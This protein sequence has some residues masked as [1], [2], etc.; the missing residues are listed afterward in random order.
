MRRLGPFACFCFI[1]AA[2]PAP[3]ADSRS[4]VLVTGREGTVGVFDS[5]TLTPI[6]AIQSGAMTQDVSARPDGRMLFVASA[7][8]SKPQSC[9][10]VYSVDLAD[11]QLC[12][13]IEPAL[14]SVPA[15]DGSRLFVQRGNVG[16]DAVDAQSLARLPAIRAPGVYA[17]SPS[18]DG[19]WLAGTTNW[20][21]PSL[22]FFDLQRSVLAR[23]LAVPFGS[24]SGA[25]A[26]GDYYL[27]SFDGKQGALWKASPDSGSLGTGVPVAIP[28]V[29][30]E[31]QPVQQRLI[32]GS[33]RLFLYEMFGAKV[34]RRAHC[35]S[36]V[37]GGAYE[38]DPGTGAILGRLAP[39]VWFRNLVASDDGETLFGIDANVPRLIAVDRRTGSVQTERSL[40]PDVW[41]VSLA[42]IPEALVPQGNWTPSECRR[43]TAG[44]R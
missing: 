7:M 35:G 11:G 24:P 29:E 23:R 44:I 17:L 1:L 33:G 31:C 6:G 10:A 12:F 27:Y 22:D 32:S 42:R 43:A 40:A 25:W 30:E 38:I 13:L 5:T 41:S 4:V 16:I 8:R 19:H 15:T 39:A 28:G 26:G 37:A 3:A 34:D 20:Q 18:P 36:P 2:A 9:C 21:G 14:N